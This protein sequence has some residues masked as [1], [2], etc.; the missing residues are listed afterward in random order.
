[1]DGYNTMTAPELITL[2]HKTTQLQVS[3]QAGGGIVRFW[4]EDSRGLRDWLRPVS[5]A[6]L[7]KQQG[8]AMGSYPLVPYCNR[9]R[10]GRFT[11]QGRAV[12]LPLNALPMRHS[13]H[14][15]GWQVAWQV[16]AATDEQLTLEYQH[17]ADAWPWDYQVRQS[18]SLGRQSLQITLQLENRGDDPMPAG[19]GI[20]PY[21][22]RTPQT[23]VLAEVDKI[24]LTDEEIMPLERVTPDPARNPK[25]GIWVDQVAL[26]NNYTGWQ[27]LARIHWPEW[28]AEMTLSADSPFDY[29]VIYSP[30][31]QPIVCVEPV[32]HT[33]DAVNQT[34][35][36][37]TGL[38]ILEPGQMFS[39]R[40]QLQYA[41]IG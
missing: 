2:R 14:G 15:Q 12:Q 3:P 20:H 30:A 21:F 1:M 29:L 16:I 40:V 7:A 4:H 22:I 34:D 38:H 23:R 8:R 32:S 17:Q 37:D 24:W 5:Q 10:E 11:F 13:L 36:D 31:E 35:A 19:L 9:I 18:F 25:Q 28:G 39:A 33:T 6:A 27:G 26:D 41:F